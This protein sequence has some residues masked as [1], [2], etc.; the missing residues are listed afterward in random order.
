VAV[1][2]ERGDEFVTMLRRAL[3]EVLG[4]GKIE[5]DAFEGM[6]QGGHG[7]ASVLVID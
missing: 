5:P 1:A 4:A 3:R 6:R 7:G 2:G